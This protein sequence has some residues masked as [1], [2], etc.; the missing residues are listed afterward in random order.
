M[1]TMKAKY[2]IRALAHMASE[3]ERVWSARHI[4]EQ[5]GIPFKFLEAILL[6]LRQSKLIESKRGLLGGH[7]L[8]KPPEKISIASIIRT[9][10]EMIA[11]IP[12]ASLYKYVPCADCKQPAACEIRHLMTDVRNAMSE[13]L[14]SR[15]LADLI[16]KKIS[17]NEKA[18]S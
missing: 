13:I 8:A 5:A 4:A 1:L 2:G 9:L 3:P 7:R 15:T 17:T 12:C 10:D 14:D 18:A 11:P 6:E 16:P